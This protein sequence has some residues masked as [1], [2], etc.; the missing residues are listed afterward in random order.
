M[1]FGVND[2]ENLEHVKNF[3]KNFN[4]W[5]SDYR[6]LHFFKSRH[7]QHMQEH[8]LGW[9]IPPEHSDMVHPHW[10]GFL[11]PAKYWH[12]GLA[13]VY[14]MLMVLSLVGNGCVVWIFTT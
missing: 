10:R 9:N 8:L 12:I 4:V 2:L 1:K 13:L 3:L 7:I 11:A 6:Y 14:F 5:K